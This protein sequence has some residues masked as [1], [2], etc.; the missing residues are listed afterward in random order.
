MNQ[1]IFITLC[2]LSAAL[3]GL[4]AHA[5]VNTDSATNGVSVL[6]SDVS[7]NATAVIC[8]AATAEESNAVASTAALWHRASM[9]T[10][11]NS[12]LAQVCASETNTVADV[13]PTQSL[14]VAWARIR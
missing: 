9:M 14:S 10:E 2:V 12:A 1:R 13:A 7:T 6:T 3:V 11:T 4:V 8:A 5:R